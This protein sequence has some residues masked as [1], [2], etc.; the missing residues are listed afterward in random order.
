VRRLP[1]LAL[2][3]G[4]VLAAFAGLAC[5]APGGAA[6][7]ETEVLDR[8]IQAH[9]AGKYDEATVAYFETLRMDPK[10]KYAFYNLGQIARLSNRF[11]AAESYYRLA[12]EIDPDLGVALFGLAY[13]LSAQGATQEAIDVYARTVR[14]EPENAAAH[15]NLGLLLR[16][17]GRIA[18]GDAEVARGLQL[19]PNVGPRPAPLASPAATGR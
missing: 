9:N 15:Y 13:A 10:N 8:A 17:V 19:D 1:E 7:S 6:E 18:E 5:G 4:L 3:V 14:V 16:S 11:V 12:L 2:L